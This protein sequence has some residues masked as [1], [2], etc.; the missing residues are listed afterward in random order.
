ME[1]QT[2]VKKDTAKDKIILFVIGVLV[3]AVI[4]AGAFLISV[5]TLGGNRGQ[6][7]GGTP[8]EMSNGQNSQGGP[9]GQGG[10]NGQGGPNGSS[11]QNGQNGQSSQN[12][13]NGQPPEKPSDDNDSKSDE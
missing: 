8:P 3:G 4:S 9:S 13:Q 5:N 1:N 12:G 6:M 7:T 10:M 11:D 2:E